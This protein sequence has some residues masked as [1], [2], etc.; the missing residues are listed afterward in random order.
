MKNHYYLTDALGSVVALTDEAGTK[1]NT[2]AHSPSGVQRTTTTT[3]QAPQPHRFADG[4]PD[5]TGLLSLGGIA[6]ALGPVGEAGTGI[7]HRAEGDTKALWG[8]V[9]GVAVGGIVAAGCAT[10]VGATATPTLG[11]LPGATADCYAIS[12][13][14]CP[15]SDDTAGLLAGPGVERLIAVSAFGEPSQAAAQRGCRRHFAYG[16]R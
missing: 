8:D 5:P 7:A 12:W 10:A 4:Y 9:G 11:A 15:A 13:I 3:E 2:Y 1:V 16:L 6:D 14:V